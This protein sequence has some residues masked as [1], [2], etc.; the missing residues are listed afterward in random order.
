MLSGDY[1]IKGLQYKSLKNYTFVDAEDLEVGSIEDLLLDPKTLEPTHLM[2]GAGFFEEYME[3]VG[4]RPDIDELADINLMEIIDNSTIHINSKIGDLQRTDEDGSIPFDTIPF[5]TISKMTYILGES[6]VEGDLL[7]FEINGSESKFIFQFP[8]MHEK[9]VMLGYKQRVIVAISIKQVV[10]E[11]NIFK[12]KITLD[13]IIK[14]AESEIPPL[15][16]GKS[17]LTIS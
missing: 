13:Q 10:V 7:D 11:N 1:M 9:L 5:S 8:S 3:V 2:L 4:K 16:N 17:V 14:R 6:T 15:L 12:I